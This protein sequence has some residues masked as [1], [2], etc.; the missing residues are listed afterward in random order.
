MPSLCLKVMKEIP[1]QDALPEFDWSEFNWSEF[2][3][4]FSKVKTM[5]R[6]SCSSGI[7]KFQYS[8]HSAEVD[9]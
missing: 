9:I 4:H 1:E 6:K 3:V 8:F 2:T 5:I 7:L